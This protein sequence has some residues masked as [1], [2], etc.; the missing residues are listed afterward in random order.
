MIDHEMAELPLVE[1]G[2]G[3]DLMLTLVRADGSGVS[4]LLGASEAVA[5]ADDLIEAA[6]VRMGRQDWPPA[7]LGC[8]WCGVGFKRRSD[9]GKAQ[10]FCSLRCRRAFDGAARAWVRQAVEAGTLNLDNLR[11]AS[12]ATRALVTEANG[13]AEVVG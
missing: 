9:G 2:E 3:A 7:H 4:L 6:R 10:R 5:L 12:P 13:T 1:A 8:F 11:K